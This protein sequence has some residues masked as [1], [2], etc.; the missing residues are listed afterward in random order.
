MIHTT[1][2]IA[3]RSI[4]KRFGIGESAVYRHQQGHIAESLVK[5]KEAT[6]AADADTLLNRV[7]R[8]LDDALRLT[9]QAE[10]AKQLDTALRGIREVRGCLQLLG[11]VSGE[12]KTQLRVSGNVAVALK[13]LDDPALNEARIAELLQKAGGMESFRPASDSKPN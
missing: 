2:S 7:M 10:K 8:L 5:A 3:Y 1:L 13:G 11:Q 9:N 6:E 12:L 4:A